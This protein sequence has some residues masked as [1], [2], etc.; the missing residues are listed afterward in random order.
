MAKPGFMYAAVLKAP[1]WVWFGVAERRVLSSQTVLPPTAK[2]Q[3]CCSYSAAIA[4]LSCRDLRLSQFQKHQRHWAAMIL[5]ACVASVSLQS[6]CTL[7]AAQCCHSPTCTALALSFPSPLH[8]RSI[9]VSAKPWHCCDPGHTLV[10]KISLAPSGLAKGRLL[11]RPKAKA[12]AACF[13]R[14]NMQVTWSNARLCWG[15]QMLEGGS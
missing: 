12:L 9:M 10:W 6:K 5:D 4:P 7:H 15:S 2:Q 1:V 14:G 8:P 11:A 13:D 3:T